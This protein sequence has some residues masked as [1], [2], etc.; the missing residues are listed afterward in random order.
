MQLDRRAGR[1]LEHMYLTGAVLGT[2]LANGVAAPTVTMVHG[3]I[4]ALGAR[5]QAVET[6]IAA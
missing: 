5:P 1:P 6:E 4:D 3:L 2:A